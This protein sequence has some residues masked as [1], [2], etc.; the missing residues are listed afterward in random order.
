[1]SPQRGLGRASAR[2]AGLATGSK[3]YVR[4]LG[5]VYGHSTGAAPGQK[6]F[7]RHIYTIAAW[8]DFVRLFAI[9]T[10]V[11]VCAGGSRLGIARIDLDPRAPGANVIGDAFRLP[12]RDHSVDTIACDPM[13]NLGFDRRVHLQRELARVARRRIL[14]KAPWIP[15]ARRFRL[16]E[17]F[18][19]AS[20]TC[21][22]VA[23]LSVLEA[24]GTQ[25]VLRITP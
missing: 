3:A 10:L 17:I 25:S 7:Y 4:H 13:Y 23:V 16:I 19:L 15:R 11:Q 1:L 18:L 22:N 20:H 9:G 2:P 14:F 24:S 5:R 12:L 21:Q 8:D 6:Q